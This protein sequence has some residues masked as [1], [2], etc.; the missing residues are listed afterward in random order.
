M[1]EG[2][3]GQAV[4]QGGKAGE[5][6][7]QAAVPGGSA[8]VEHTAGNNCILWLLP[9]PSW[10]CAVIT[11]PVMAPRGRRHSDPPETHRRDQQHGQWLL[12]MLWVEQSPLLP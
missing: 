3:L 8:L 7:L 4:G 1:C 10:G 9:G 2:G 6:G 12:E 5:C 11:A